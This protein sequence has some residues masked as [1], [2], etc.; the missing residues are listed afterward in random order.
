MQFGGFAVPMASTDAPAGGSREK[1]ARW[2][3]VVK[4][5][6]L[7]RCRRVSSSAA[8]LDAHAAV[9]CVY[10]EQRLGETASSHDHEGPNCRVVFCSRKEAHDERNEVVTGARVPL[11]IFRT[12]RDYRKIIQVKLLF[13]KTC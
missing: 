8:G 10:I 3:Y 13:L 2:T 7:R 11:Y 12:P 9:L 1:C 5:E 4:P 6:R